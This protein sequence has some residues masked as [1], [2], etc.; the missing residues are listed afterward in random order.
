MKTRYYLFYVIIG[1]INF[2]C[3]KSLETDVNFDVN[4]KLTEQVQ[5]DEN[6]VTVKKGIP[7]EFQI[8][9]NPNFMTFFSGEEGHQYK[10]KN[11]RFV[12]ED[13]L[14]EC[15]LSFSLY[16]GKFASHITPDILRIYISDDFPGLAK[17]N[18]E[19][20]SILVESH[21]W[22]DLVTLEEL[23]QS[24]ILSADEAVKYNIDLKPHLGKRFTIAIR[25]LVTET[26][27]KLRQPGIFF[28]KAQIVTT[29]KNGISTTMYPSS[30]GLT[31]LNMRYKEFPPTD[32][33][34]K[35]NPAYGTTKNNVGGYWNLSYAADGNFRLWGEFAGMAYPK[36]Y[37]WLVSDPIITN[38]CLPDVGVAIKNIT[39][40][41]Y[42][43]TY[44][45]DNPGIYKATFLG[46][47]TNYEH[48]SSQIVEFE[49]H[50]I[51]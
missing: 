20:D 12:G 25:Y 51:E 27:E 50:V 34:L 28:E 39:T 2:S 24:P 45:Y 40:T 8:T 21:Q 33:I 22:N 4:I 11:R 41:L 49:I 44:K 47:N 10:Y 43:Y 1:L 18:F 7:I 17:N 42:S 5:Y 29:L 19:S 15:K 46:K 14:Q 36:H 38:S 32:A 35:E 37:N 3:D 9:G 48:S 26:V 6:I 13:D 30:W 16:N 23:P 31:P